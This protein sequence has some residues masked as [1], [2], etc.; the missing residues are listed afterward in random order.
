MAHQAR[1]IP[2]QRAAAPPPEGTR[3]A[4]D[5]AP[6]MLLA[7]SSYSG[8]SAVATGLLR[9]LTDRGR[10]VRP[11]KA[12]WIGPSSDDDRAR[13]EER[14]PLGYLRAACRLS[15]D[16]IDW[17]MTPAV[18][19]MERHGTGVL[20]LAS[21]RTCRVQVV[22]R[23]NLIAAD[24]PQE[25]ND[26][27]RRA[28]DDGLMALRAESDFVVIEGSGGVADTAR[29]DIPNIWVARRAAAKL[30]LVGNV[31]IGGVVAGLV[32]IYHLLPDDLRREVVGFVLANA[33]PEEDTRM[34]LSD[35]I[36]SATGVHLLSH[37]P[38]AEIVVGQPERTYANFAS[39]V[40]THMLPALTRLPEFAAL[41]I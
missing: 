16:T 25:V 7:P 37:L 26:E 36:C 41:A 18:V 17:R 31:A 38:T 20:T 27:M 34:G 21:G 15:I 22:G 5:I 23:D 30:V 35:R 14:A 3:D 8:K 6:L 1:R 33:T 10:R 9:A 11:F 2:A 28:I 13:V 19:T 12:V 24:L 4:A 29:E 40:R 32:G 39:L